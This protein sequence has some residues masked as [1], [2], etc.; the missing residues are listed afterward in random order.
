V[1]EVH[2]QFKGKN[3]FAV[4]LQKD[5]GG[6]ELRNKYL[7]NSCSP[8]DMTSIKKGNSKLL[9]TEGMFDILSLTEIN[10]NLESEYDFLIMNS[11]GFL[12]KV[13]LI[14]K[15]YETVDLY[16]DTDSNGKLTTENLIHHSK[17][18][19]DKSKLYDG[20]K[21]VND[22]LIDRAK[23]GISQEAQDVFLLPQK[24]T[25]FTPDGC[26]ENKK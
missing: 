13:K 20:F 4:G 11:I 23:K 25:C 6:W 9:I 5:S 7:K 17:N 8:K 2:Y 12:E 15:E 18:F 24:Q 3:Y 14:S 1:K 26:K 19:K 16:L 10:K 21:D 22:W